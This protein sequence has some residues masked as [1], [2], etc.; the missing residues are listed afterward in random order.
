MTD[1]PH[2]LVE[3]LRSYSNPT[4]RTD[5]VAERN[6]RSDQRERIY[7]RDQ[8]ESFKELRA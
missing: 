3:P 1:A 2:D 8:Q 5:T 7:W 4:S 6:G